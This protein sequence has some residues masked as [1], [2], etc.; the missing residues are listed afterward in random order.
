MRICHLSSG[1]RPDDDRIFFKE[2]CS[3]AKRYPDV[4][5]LSPHPEHLPADPDGVRI[6]TFERTKGL[7]GR[8]G[9]VR[10]L[11]RK[12]LE[13]GADLYHCHEPE[14]LLAAVL[15]KRKRGALVIFDSHELWE[16]VLSERGPRLVGAAA[17]RVY[18]VVEKAL[19]KRCDGG[20]AASQPI[21]DHL[22]ETLGSNR[23]D[24]LLNVPVPGVFGEGAAR[25]WG[26]ETVLC[27]DGYLTFDRGL[28]TMAEAVRRTA[29]K[30][31]V[32]FKIVGDVFDEERAWL[33]RFVAE[34]KLGGTIV[35][36]GWLPYTEVGRAM[37][38]CHIGLVAFRRCPNHVVAAPNKVFN[39]LMYGMPFVGPDFNLTMQAMAAED[40]VCTLADPASPESYAGA[41]C[42][43]IEDRAGTEAMAARALKASKEKYRW[44]HMEPRLFRLYERVL[45]ARREGAGRRT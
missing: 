6:I 26:E 39:Y 34:H 24:T 11:Y 14:S 31:R 35:R 28:R 9:A 16:G 4:E 7:L 12:G 41:L 43:M 2:A 27:H 42:R 13:R 3:L 36:T 45:G 29:E 17:A 5:L 8:M 18:R 1:H 44:E 23:V 22:A 30:H 20:F 38:P 25:A 37:A 21:A 32:V 15:I 10:Q 19:L 40:G 33:D